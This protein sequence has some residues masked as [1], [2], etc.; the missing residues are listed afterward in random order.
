[1]G[2]GGQPPAPAALP[3]GKTRY[4]LYLDTIRYSKLHAYITVIIPGINYR[5]LVILIGHHKIKYV[6]AVVQSLGLKSAIPPTHGP[7]P[8][9][10]FNLMMTFATLALL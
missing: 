10:A 1:M 3:P 7:T 5:I 4:P 6:C 9:Y 2:V 8:L